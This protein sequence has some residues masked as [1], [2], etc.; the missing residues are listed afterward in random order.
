MIKYACTQNWYVKYDSSLVW[1][2]VVAIYS[3]VWLKICCSR[4]FI[5]LYVGGSKIWYLHSLM[6]F[7][8]SNEMQSLLS[9]SQ[10][11]M[12]V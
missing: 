11:R 6:P 9:Y 2:R 4:Y 5:G 12:T 1:Y 3:Q 8:W 10:N 7:H